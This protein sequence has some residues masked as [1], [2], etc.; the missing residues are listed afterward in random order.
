M[1]SPH[2][3][4]VPLKQTRARESEAEGEKGGESEAERATWG[5]RGVRETKKSMGGKNNED[6]EEN[7]H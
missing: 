7:S 2:A 5:E 1:S 4:P 6:L 3:I